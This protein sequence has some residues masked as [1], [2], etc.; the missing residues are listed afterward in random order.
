M[1][2]IILFGINALTACLREA[3]RRGRQRRRVAELVN[4]SLRLRVSAVKKVFH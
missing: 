2:E 4:S 3:L 1:I